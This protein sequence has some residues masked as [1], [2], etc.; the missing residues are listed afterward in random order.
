MEARRFQIQ[1]AP[2]HT[3]PKPVVPPPPGPAKAAAPSSTRPPKLEPAKVAVPPAPA[4]PK[5]V[6]S[7]P[8][9]PQKAVASSPA[10]T[11]KG[12][13]L[14]PGSIFADS[15]RVM[16]CIG[17]GST[18]T[19]YAAERLSLNKKVAIKVLDSALSDI[20]NAVARFQREALATSRIDH[21][22]VAGASDCGRL[23]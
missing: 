19:V 16:S 12:I 8:P 5:P 18:G 2:P 15:Y 11:P 3:P 17:Q 13:S 7:S 21:P 23:D 6:V 1:P 14:A 4:P 20:P 22:N 10:S 9:L